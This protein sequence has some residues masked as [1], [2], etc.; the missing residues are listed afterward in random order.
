MKVYPRNL[1]KLHEPYDE[2]A[3][4]FNCIQPALANNHYL[5]DA[6]ICDEQG[7]V[8]PGYNVSPVPILKD[9]FNPVPLHELES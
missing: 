2:D 9:S 6:W 5:F 7:R 1:Y 4:E 8:H 3:P